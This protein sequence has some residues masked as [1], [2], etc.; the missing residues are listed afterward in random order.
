LSFKVE[1]F[2]V[3]SK[4]IYLSSSQCKCK[5]NNLLTCIKKPYTENIFE[6]E[7]YNKTLE[8]ELDHFGLQKN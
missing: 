3:H 2:I 8:V 1:R 6:K 4:L 7:S 5:S